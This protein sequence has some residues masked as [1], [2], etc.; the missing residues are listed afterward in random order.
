MESNGGCGE[1]PTRCILVVVTARRP[2]RD[3]DSMVSSCHVVCGVAAALRRRVLHIGAFSLRCGL[4]LLDPCRHR[5]A[6]ADFKDYLG[7]LLVVAI[8]DRAVVEV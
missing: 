4:L 6:F 5:V 8:S 7:G 2:V 1:A 3:P